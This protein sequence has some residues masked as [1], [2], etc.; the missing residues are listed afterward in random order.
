[1]QG[2]GNVGSHAARIM[3]S[4]GARLLAVNDHTGSIANPDGI[5]AED[6][7]AYVAKKGGVEGYG[8]AQQVSLTDFFSC[9]ADIFIPAALE[10]TINSETEGYIRAKFIVEGANG[11]TTPD[12]EQ[13]L[14][15]R[16]IVVVPDIL[17]NSGG[18]TVSYFEWVQNK[19]S[20]SWDLLRVDEELARVMH[21]ATHDVIDEIESRQC[22]PRTAAMALALARLERIYKERGIFP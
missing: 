19:N 2:F 7:A 11:P 9:K 16:G 12:A 22:E 4:R 8:R 14:A 10:C 13:K 1:V 5:D 17:A 20:E 15:R 18:V 21:R 3:Q 6:L